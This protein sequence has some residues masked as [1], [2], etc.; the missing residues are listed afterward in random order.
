MIVSGTNE[1]NNMR[2]RPKCEANPFKTLLYTEIFVQP[3]N[4]QVKIA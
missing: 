1:D 2:Q 3:A 4:T